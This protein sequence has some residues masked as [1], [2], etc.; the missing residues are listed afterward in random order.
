MSGPD[1]NLWV[2]EADDQHIARITTSGVCTEFSTK[3]TGNQSIT[4][5]RARSSSGRTG[6]CISLRHGGNQPTPASI[7][8]ITTAGVVQHFSIYESIPP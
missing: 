2:T 4:T 8:Q 3:T 6:T 1:G 7:G 5:L